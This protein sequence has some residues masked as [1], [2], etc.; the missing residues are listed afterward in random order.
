MGAGR[1]QLL[2]TIFG[3]YPAR[4]VRGESGWM[5]AT[6]KIISPKAAIGARYWPDCRRSEGQSLV[7][8]GQ[9]SKCHAGDAPPVSHPVKCGKP[10]YR[11]PGRDEVGRDLNIKTPASERWSAI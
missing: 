6:V 1:T 9:S 11:R 5:A 2:E 8:E 10:A 7:L 4:T 3:V